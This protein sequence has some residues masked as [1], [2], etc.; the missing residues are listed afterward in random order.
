MTEPKLI[1]LTGPAGSG[2]DTIADYLCAKHGFARYAYADP[3]RLEVA[4][5]FGISVDILIDRERKEKP[6]DLLALECCSDP[7][8]VASLNDKHWVNHNFA[9]PRS[10]RWI[11]QQWGT[12]Y[13]REYDGQDYWIR[14]AENAIADMDRAGITRIVITDARFEDEADFVRNKRGQIWHVHRPDLS[15]VHAHISERGI[16]ICDEDIEIIN[17]STI[18]N[19]HTQVA[20]MLGGRIAA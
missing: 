20:L 11:M 12:N 10:P 7:F 5:A 17:S 15:A 9:L 8:F 2:K 19:L 1:G 4:T 6:T 16:A 13:R 14:Q 18:G 3:L